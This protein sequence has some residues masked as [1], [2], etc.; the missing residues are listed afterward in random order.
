M[1]QLDQGSARLPNA[2]TDKGYSPIFVQ[3]GPPSLVVDSTIWFTRGV[4]PIASFA[5][6]SAVLSARVAGSAG[7][8]P[9]RA[10]PGRAGSEYNYTSNWSGIHTLHVL[11]LGLNRGVNRQ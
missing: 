4:K 11:S 1:S 3:S 5:S 6:S 7:P 9:V 10:A 2:S 8:S